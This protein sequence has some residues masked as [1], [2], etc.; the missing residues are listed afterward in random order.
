MKL[1]KKKTKPKKKQP[2]SNKQAALAVPYDNEM[3]LAQIIKQL[4]AILT[5][6]QFV[7]QHIIEQMNK[8][9][10]PI[11]EPSKPQVLPKEPFDWFKEIERRRKEKEQEEEVWPYRIG[12]PYPPYPRWPTPAD[13]WVPT[14]PDTYPYP[15]KKQPIITC[16]TPNPLS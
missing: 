6:L 4:G 12:D 15:D 14:T 11:P 10:A 8:S 9:P 7:S 1:V 2:K 13:P 5:E 16:N 3:A